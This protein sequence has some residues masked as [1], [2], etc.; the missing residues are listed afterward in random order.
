MGVAAEEALPVDLFP[1]IRRREM[2]RILYV[3]VAALFLAMAQNLWGHIFGELSS[4]I[5]RAL[6]ETPPASREMT[7]YVDLAS[8]FRLFIS[9]L[10]GAGL[11]EELLFRVGLMTMIWALTRR[12]GW[13]L[14]V[15][16]ILF[17]LY[18]ISL[19]GMAT[20]FLQAPLS[21]VLES[22]GV[23]LAVGTIY[24]Y[25]GFTAVVLMHALGNWLMLLL[26]A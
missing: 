22:F 6:G 7:S 17:G 11:F 12:W 5:G 9:M 8:S 23:G 20:Y 19:S 13:G 21:A 15:S 2:R 3:I 16:A 25:R 1:V 4:G 14:L 24:R 10:I 18:H 26:L